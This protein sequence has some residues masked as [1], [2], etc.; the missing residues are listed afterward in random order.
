MDDALRGSLEIGQ[1][2]GQLLMHQCGIYQ[3]LE[4]KQK[5]QRKLEAKETKYE[6]GYK[7]EA[8]IISL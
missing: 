7:N 6:A 3:A 2:R 1:Q 4:E 5:G 8:Q